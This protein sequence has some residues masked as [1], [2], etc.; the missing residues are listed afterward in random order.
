MI[1]VT[2]SGKPNCAKAL[3]EHSPFPIK[4]VEDWVSPYRSLVEVSESKEAIE[5]L[6]VR[7]E[8]FGEHR[9]W[10]LGAIVS[11]WPTHGCD[12]PVEGCVVGCC[13]GDV[14]A[15]PCRSCPTTHLSGS[16]TGP[17]LLD[18]VAPFLA[19]VPIASGV[20]PALAGAG[21]DGLSLSSSDCPTLFLCASL[22]ATR[23]LLRVGV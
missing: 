2:S 23:C 3:Q 14:V 11:G 1:L 16:S 19:S 7:C 9:P 8:L 6:H 17:K 4:G 10:D 22:D 20:R 18:D 5:L 12:L 15:V 21:W 13:V